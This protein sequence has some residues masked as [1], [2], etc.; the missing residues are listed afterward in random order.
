MFSHKKII[1]YTLGSFHR[2]FC[3]FQ[4]FMNSDNTEPQLLWINEVLFTV[5]TRY[6]NKQT[7]IYLL[8]LAWYTMIFSD[9]YFVKSYPYYR[10]R[11]STFKKKITLSVK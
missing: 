2:L 8:I 5:P 11:R 1:L 3:F 10:C 9:D 4:T 7:Q 6:I